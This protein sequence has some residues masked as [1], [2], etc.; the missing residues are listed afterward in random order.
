[1]EKNYQTPSIEVIEIK[2]EGIIAGSTQDMPNKEWGSNAISPS[3]MEPETRVDD[4][5]MA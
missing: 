3:G 1:M 5:L 4:E 2:V